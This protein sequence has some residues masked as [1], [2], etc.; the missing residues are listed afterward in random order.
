MVPEVVIGESSI[1]VGTMRRWGG[2]LLLTT[3]VLAA[4]SAFAA[5]GDPF[6][7]L[8]LDHWAYKSITRME[9]AGYYT[10][11]PKGAFAKKLT[12]YEIAVTTERIYRSL[13]TRALSAVDPGAMREDIRLYLKLLDEFAPEIADLGPDVD[14]MRKELRAQDDRLFRQQ[15]SL[16]ANPIAKPS[17]AARSAS[18][19]S[20]LNLSPNTFG[21][22]GALKDRLLLESL[23]AAP[24]LR[25]QN[26]N[27]GTPALNGGVT[28]ALGPVH[29]SAEVRPNNDL[30]TPDDTLF[31]DSGDR[32]NSLFKAS[33]PFG[34]SIET[35]FFYS[36]SSS[37]FDR[38]GL[39]PAQ[40]GP[41]DTLGG[42]ISGS[43]TNRLGFTLQ[44][45]NFLDRVGGSG[46][47]N[48]LSGGLSLRWKDYDFAL[49]YERMRMQMLGGGGNF[50]AYTAGVGRKFGSNARLDLQ[51]RFSGPYTEGGA[52]GDAGGSSAITSFTV[53]F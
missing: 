46:K 18:P 26:A 49:G 50:S 32:F 16:A 19:A 15:Q 29:L 40:L 22:R 17:S 28:T 25:T 14:A 48:S 5:Q 39:L 2:R 31:T 23:P 30:E 52:R 21:L 47:G 34:R 43:I 42:G 1:G 12:R 38:F 9:N 35:E 3:L 51:L 4:S 41:T 24:P 11:A 53:R 33:V 6:K 45:V 44:S 36:R 7:P 37:R 20:N 8:P 10:G 13:Q 27:G